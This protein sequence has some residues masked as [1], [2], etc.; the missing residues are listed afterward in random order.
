[1]NRN[2]NPLSMPSL[3]P[4]YDSERNPTLDGTMQSWTLKS[5]GPCMSQVNPYC[6]EIVQCVLCC[7]NSRKLPSTEDSRMAPF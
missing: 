3:P 1:M 4:Y 6:S 7:Y 5:P 2:V